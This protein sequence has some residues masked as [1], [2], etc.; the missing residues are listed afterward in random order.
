MEMQ[1][2][3]GEHHDSEIVLIGHLEVGYAAGG[4]IYND[5]AGRFAD[6]IQVVTSSVVEIGDD[7]FR[8]RNTV[9]KIL[10]GI[11]VVDSVDRIP[12]THEIARAMLAAKDVPLYALRY[13]GDL[14]GEYT[15]MMSRI[16]CI[17]Y[18]VVKG[19]AVVVQE[20]QEI[21]I[22]ELEDQ[23]YNGK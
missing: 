13:E 9:Y 6:G 5:K 16:S 3:N 22:A 12:T 19:A 8:T 11:P 21:D 7:W 18:G 23:L 20:E 17:D 4:Y 2:V 10:K 14:E 15:S 1:K